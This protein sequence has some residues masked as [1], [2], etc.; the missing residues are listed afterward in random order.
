[1]SDNPFD[2][3]A[4]SGRL[5]KTA[6]AVAEALTSVTLRV[7]SEELERGADDPATAIATAMTLYNAIL[8]AFVAGTA[9]SLVAHVN[10]KPEE[11]E[12]AYDDF[13]ALLVGKLSEGV[14]L[15]RDK[16]LEKL[17]AIAAQN[18]A[19]EEGKA[20]ENV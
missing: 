8:D 17:K 11:V 14:G 12:R 4:E 18:H 3:K 5:I 2:N 1:M 6:Q 19:A 7:L 10:A 20:S 16:A 9:T 13:V 15:Y